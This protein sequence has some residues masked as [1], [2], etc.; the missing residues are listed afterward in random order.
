MTTT[1]PVSSSPDIK[2]FLCKWTPRAIVVL[3][4]GYYGLGIAYSC[5]LMALID[6]IAMAIFGHVMG[7]AG[8]GA[9][10]PTFQWYSAWS[11]RVAIAVVAGL[12]YDL[13]ERAATYC[14][15][16]ARNYLSLRYAAAIP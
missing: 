4:G 7:Y 9:F 12:I 6:K 14:F 10:M 8:I 2:A 16:H 11:V 3:I 13:I 5:G 1:P 15:I